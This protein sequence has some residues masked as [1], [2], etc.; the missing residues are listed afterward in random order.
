MRVL[1]VL[2]WRCQSPGGTISVR[3]SSNSVACTERVNPRDAAPGLEARHVATWVLNFNDAFQPPTRHAC[4]DIESDTIVMHERPQLKQV[5]GRL[6]FFSLAFGAM[7]GVGWITGLKQMFE[8]AGPVGTAIAFVAGGGLM[9]VIG[10]CYAETMQRLPVTGGEVAY[11]Y[12]AFGTRQAFVIG[13]CLA[14]GYLSVSAFEAVSIGVVISY[15]VDV[16]LWPLYE[17]QNSTVYGSHVAIALLFTLG[18]ALINFR[19]VG[20]ATQV[21]TAMTILLIVFAAT[22]VTAGFWNGDVGHLAPAFGS[23][24]PLTAL[25]GLLAVFVTVPFWYVGFD[26]IPQAAEERLDGL[27]TRHLGQMLVLAVAGSTI[28]YV[29]VFLSVGMLVPWKSIISD[30]LPTAVAFQKAFDSTLWSRLVLV[31][32]LIGLLT[33]W[34]GF[35]LSGCRVLFALGRGH[36]I[37]P[38]FGSSHPRFGTPSAAIVFSAAITFSG[39]LLGRQAVLV[40]VNVGSFCIALAF[41]GVALSLQTMRKE[42]TAKF[43]TAQRLLPRVAA[44]GSTLILG[45]MIVPGSP[46]RLPWPVEWI[47]L[48]VVL[49]TGL[50]FWIGARRVRHQLPK[51]ERR[52]LILDADTVT[53]AAVASQPPD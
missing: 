9:I 32:G 27:P 26:T 52:R 35:F 33:S 12:Q 47:V 21:Q 39:A 28:F 51:T 2:S 24:Q 25:G 42:T 16:D 3:G 43:S 29:A 38:I 20:L 18:I 10:L 34:N 17:I 14:F 13:W 30:P 1:R 6:G 19:G 45:A 4:P 11:A 7:I 15:I 8:N 31:V 5:I 22:F 23:R 48:S 40:F 41:L 46:A 49:L 53:S 50:G 37:H 36:I 44:G